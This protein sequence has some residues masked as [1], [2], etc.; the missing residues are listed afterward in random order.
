[1]EILDKLELTK[2]N[3]LKFF[4]LTNEELNKSY[5]LD[6][7]TVRYILHHIADAETVMYDRVRR[8]ISEPK[9]VIW[10]FNQDAWA[11]GL[12]YSN[13]PLELS[14]NIYAS[15]REAIIYYA[16]LHYTQ[17]GNLEFVHSET[18]IRTLKDEFDKVVWHNEKHLE[19][20]QKSLES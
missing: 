10:A 6:K 20:I 5:G 12:D 2:K 18:G 13:V 4:A 3:T 1:M 8:V 9:Q 11:K 19:Q 15:V 14:R 17:N 16:R 7:W